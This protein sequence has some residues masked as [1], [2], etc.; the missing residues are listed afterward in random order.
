[1]HPAARLPRYDFKCVFCP[2]S[3]HNLLSQF[4]STLAF[5]VCGDVFWWLNA[6]LPLPSFTCYT[7]IKLNSHLS[8]VPNFSCFVSFVAV[9][10]RS[11]SPLSFT[12]VFIISSPSSFF[13][14]LSPS[15]HFSD[16]FTA[17]YATASLTRTHTQTN[18]RRG[19]GGGEEAK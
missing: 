8:I 12:Q 2:P 17:T 4:N 19:E 18:Y 13:K 16:W 11:F 15:L 5:P 7:H 3:K 6:K 1:M 14:A 9:E 10:P